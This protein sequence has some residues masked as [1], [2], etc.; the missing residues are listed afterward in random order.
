MCMRVYIASTH[1]CLC[2]CVPCVRVHTFINIKKGLVR[3]SLAPSHDA[4]SLHAEN[5]NRPIPIQKTN[6]YYR[7]AKQQL[8]YSE[9]SVIVTIMRFV[10]NAPLS[11]C[12]R[13]YIVRLRIVSLKVTSSW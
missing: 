1:A 10:Y 8:S 7:R 5:S 2:A 3:I 4:G 11:V 9:S 13:T 6:T 12:R